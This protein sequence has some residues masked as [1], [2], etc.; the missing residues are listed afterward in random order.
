MKK[1]LAIL[2]EV[3]AAAQGALPTAERRGPKVQHP[4]LDR[5]AWKLR[6]LLRSRCG[7]GAGVVKWDYE[8]NGY[9]G[10][11]YELVALIAPRLPPGSLPMTDREQGLG[12]QL[13]RALTRGS[14]T[15]F[16]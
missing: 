6:D 11:L 9:T 3:A 10:D 16:N 7:S 15:Q 14:R 2:P 13:Q 8:R 5:L 12:K 1:L 4:T